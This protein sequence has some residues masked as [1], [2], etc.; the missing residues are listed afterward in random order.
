MTRT[1]SIIRNLP[2]PPPPSAGLDRVPRLGKSLHWLIVQSNECFCLYNATMLHYYWIPF[3][4]H[5]Y[6]ATRSSW[7]WI[8]VYAYR[9][10]ARHIHSS[11]SESLQFNCLL[12]CAPLI[13]LHL[14]LLIGLDF[15]IHYPKYVFLVSRNWIDSIQFLIWTRVKS[16]GNNDWRRLCEN[17]FHCANT[18]PTERNDTWKNT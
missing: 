6:I 15:W 5:C 9:E 11:L 17:D 13:V 7:L 2:P 14:K 8:I 10:A 16:K 12:T 3:T 18:L 4:Q 1:W